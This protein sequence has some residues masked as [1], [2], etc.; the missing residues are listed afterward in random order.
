VAC[1]DP[2]LAISPDAASPTEGGVGADAP[3]ERSSPPDANLA[4][5]LKPDLTSPIVTDG[6]PPFDAWRACQ[7]VLTTEGPDLG[8]PLCPIAVPTE[9]SECQPVGGIGRC[10]YRNGC[11]S[12]EWDCWTGRWKRT[13]G[14]S[15]AACPDETPVNDSSCADLGETRANFTCA[16]SRPTGDGHAY[17]RCY[18][19]RWSV[20]NQNN[21][22]GCPA[23]APLGGQPCA[24]PTPLTCQYASACHS[25][26]VAVCSTDGWSV[27]AG[28]CN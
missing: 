9:G 8:V 27:N 18:N 26:D 21:P 25:I 15:C 13:P 16:W 7:V 2:M 14:R 20:A 10:L 11:D 6:E 1:T 12:D 22:A 5:D 3:A 4:F 24:G 19:C 17:A 28:R 23:T